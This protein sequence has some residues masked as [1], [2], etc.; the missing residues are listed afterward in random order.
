MDAR[1]P[2]CNDPSLEN[3]TAA[4][5]IAGTQ[6]TDPALYEQYRAQARPLA[7]RFGGAYIV[8]GGPMPAYETDLW[9]PGRLVVIRF[10]SMGQAHR[11]YASEAYQRFL[12]LSRASAR[13]TVV[14]VEG[15]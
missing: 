6:L 11:F 14:I 3:A 9:S 13:R 4:Y 12:G 15:V 8:R 2:P 7:K 5:L 1:A 10:E